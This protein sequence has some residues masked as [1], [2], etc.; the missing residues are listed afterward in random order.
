MLSIS[1]MAL[2]KKIS[3]LVLAGLGLS[4][5]LFSLLSVQSLNESTRRILEQR[6]AISRILANSVDENMTQA[7][8]HM[9][10]AA[11]LNFLPTEQES[12]VLVSPLRQTLID[13]GISVQNIFL[14]N[15]EG[16]IEQVV[17]EN[18]AILGTDWSRL[19]EVKQT[20]E[21]GK[22]VISNE[23][24]EPQT[25][26]EMVL[27]VVPFVTSQGKILGVLA[28]S[29]DPAESSIRSMSQIVQIGNTGYVEIVDGNGL[30]L[31]RTEPGVPPRLLEKS[32]HPGRFSDLIREGKAVVRTCHRCHEGKQEL[33][34]R[35]DIIA[36]APLSTI[37]WG[38]AIRQ[39]EDEALAPTRQL[40]F[41]LLSLGVILL[42]GA[43]LLVW[44]MTQG[45]VKPLKMLKAAAQRFAVGN[46]D[47]A[48][49]LR[50]GD[51]IGQLS[52]SFYTMAQ[53]LAKSRNQ[54][55]SRNKELA[56]MNSISVAVSQSLDLKQL[57]ESALQNVLKITQTTT[58]CIFLASSDGDRL[59]P[60][61]SLGS[62]V[63]FG[64]Q[65]SG[66]AKADCA[67]RQ[68]LRHRQTLMVTDVS[69]CPMLGAEAKGE[70][71]T[72][73][74][75][76]PLNSKN[77]ALGIMN[78]ACSGELYFTEKDF[79]LFNSI[80]FQVGLAM[81]NSFLYN[82][83]KQKE[84]LRGQLLSSI[85]SAQEE[86]RK[87]ISRELHD[88][89][90]QTL[91]AAIMNVESIETLIPAKESV[92]NEKIQG[93]KAL[94]AHTLE[95]IRRLTHDLRPMALDDLGLASA[96][97][98][99]V[100]NRLEPANIQVKFESK[101]LTASRRLSPA[102]ENALFRIIQEATNNIVRHA[103]AHKVDIQLSL[104]NDM[105][106]AIVEDDGRGFE[107]ESVFTSESKQSLGLLGIKERVALL[108]GTFSIKSRRY[109][110]TRLAVEI[111]AVYNPP[112]PEAKQDQAQPRP[113]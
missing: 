66:L 82:E 27:A 56:A 86:E 98:A 62:S 52:V 80:G 21:T 102:I 61:I 106:K 1:N 28:A 30:V 39:S 19:L 46:F 55:L 14:V 70:A 85:I 42:L 97:R 99:Y 78:V 54:L 18:P 33:F 110:G 74:A 13:T 71:V 15:P 67:C 109:Q 3:L 75:S 64:C 89:S 68:V 24:T 105:V 2:Q 12:N 11:A 81:E 108:G 38:V 90:G 96:I 22:P 41:R 29:I 63:I 65:K 87:R 95:D 69:Q 57:S 84:E 32:D 49:P 37:P 25:A 104:E 4:L 58:G 83:A 107:T 43:L 111:P 10:S 92:L 94:I 40:E 45:V 53:E 77:R 8:A 16:K 17:P 73:F 79:E 103:N 48:V 31:A 100:K 50:R 20:L 93:V 101:G 6:L 9:Q 26:T 76:I 7:L 44:F 59:E 35:R 51:E 36:F 72:S 112:V 91:T 113:V 60:M 47:A 88:G 23:F 5:A 34:R